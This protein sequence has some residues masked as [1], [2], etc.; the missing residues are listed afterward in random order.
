MAEAGFVGHYTNHSLRATTAT[1]LFQ[2]NCPE[3]LIAEQT[4]HSSN[5]IRRYKKASLAQKK[6]VSQLLCNEEKPAETST[7]R[8]GTNDQKAE[9]SQ[10]KKAKVDASNVH[11]NVPQCDDYSKLQGLVNIH[12][13]FSK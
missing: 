3:Q 5:A 12:F 1:R 6:E 13:H 11:V 10:P 7:E 4:G 2:H 9:I 8:V